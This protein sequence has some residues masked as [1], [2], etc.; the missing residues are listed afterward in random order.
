MPMLVTSQLRKNQKV[1]DVTF[2]NW[3]K[4]FMTAFSDKDPITKG[5]NQSFER[6]IP[7]ASNIK[8]HITKDAGHFLQE[9]K[10]P[11]LAELLIQFIEEN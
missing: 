8:P 7:G 5:G 11:E 10:G 9:D 1:W 6:N 4:P 2:R 3:T